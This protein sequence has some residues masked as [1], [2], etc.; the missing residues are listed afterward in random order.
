M[1]IRQ[2]LVAGGVTVAG[3]NVSFK[4]SAEAA[5][6]SVTLPT[7]AAGD[8][9]FIVAYGSTRPTV[10]A[11]WTTLKEFATYFNNRLCVAAYKAAAGTSEVSGTWTN[12]DYMTAA[13]YDG[14]AS[15][16]GSS[17]TQSTSNTTYPG[18][19]M[20]ESDGTSWVV[21]VGVGNGSM[22]AVPSGM[23]FRD[24][25]NTFMG[26]HDTASGVTGWGSTSAFTGST[27]GGAVTFE[28]VSE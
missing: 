8:F 15:V 16:G 20:S 28:L 2:L 17:A 1:T 13:V 4:G 21:G 23:T 22:T 5:A 14:V 9:I 25:T 19:T 26:W 10:P 18:V 24:G 3:S 27:A 12:A 7:H 6:T 11:G